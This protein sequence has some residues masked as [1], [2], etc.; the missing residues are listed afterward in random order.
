MSNEKGWVMAYQYKRCCHKGGLKI[1]RGVEITLHT[2]KVLGTKL[3]GLPSTM[4]CVEFYILVLQVEM[5]S[6]STHVSGD[7][8]IM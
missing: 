2:M 8:R 1:R 7:E 5:D 6:R 4:L 3:K